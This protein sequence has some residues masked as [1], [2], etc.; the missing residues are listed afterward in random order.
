MRKT[1][2]AMLI[3][4][5]GGTA[6]SAVNCN[7]GSRLVTLPK[8]DL[9]PKASEVFSLKHYDEKYL[10]RFIIGGITVNSDLVDQSSLRSAL[11]VYAEKSRQLADR[12]VCNSEVDLS[13]L[14]K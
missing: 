2:I 8:R 5:I 3:I 6:N 7:V 11:E 12:G 1:V 13:F 4:F 9:T 10:I 14:D